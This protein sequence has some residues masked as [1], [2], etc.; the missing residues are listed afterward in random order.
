MTRLRTIYVMRSAV[1][2]ADT[3]PQVW[4]DS[5]KGGEVCFGVK[6]SGSSL[7]VARDRAQREFKGLTA[8]VRALQ[9][10]LK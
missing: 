7:A 1:K 4:I 6:A 8:F 3:K 2:D 5:T 10:K 9:S